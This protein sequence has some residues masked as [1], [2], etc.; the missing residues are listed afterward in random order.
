MLSHFARMRSN[1]DG[2]KAMSTNTKQKI[3]NPVEITLS[4]ASKLIAEQFPQWAHLPITPVALSG[5]DNRTFRLGKKLSIRLPST[6]EYA[7]QVLKEQ[8]WLP[9][10]A[11]HVSFRIAEPRALGQPSKN[12]PWHW[13]IYRWIE[14]ESANTST[15]DDETL[16]H[17]A[18][19]LAQFLHEL[20]NIDSTGGPLPGPH[21]FWRGDHLSV[22]DTE[23]RAAIKKLHDVIDTKAATS[24]WEKA[25]SSRWHK[26]PVWIHG[27]FSSGNIL[28]KDGKLNAVIDFGCMGIGDPAC[29]LVIAWTFLKNESRAIFRKQVNLDSA[30]W[31]RA[32]GW[33]LWKALITLTTLKDKTDE[34]ALKQQ[35]II[36]EILEEHTIK[37]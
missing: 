6:E 16:R 11:P 36:S 3:S 26:N 21:N 5:I 22:Y 19:N 28:L 2:D 30:T 25:V 20:H 27:D 10:L 7:E 8:H 17:I 13:S 23:M 12:Y 37:S 33:A 24:V 9:T 18:S 35:L 1:Y 31:A 4:L 14:G 29:D 15:L 32:R 34:D